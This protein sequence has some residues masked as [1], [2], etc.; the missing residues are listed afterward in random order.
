MNIPRASIFFLISSLVSSRGS[1]AFVTRF[2]YRSRSCSLFGGNCPVSE[3][4]FGLLKVEVDQFY[5]LFDKYKGSRNLSGDSEPVS[6]EINN[7]LKN[8]IDS[9]IDNLL[10]MITMQ[11]CGMANVKHALNEHEM[12]E[13]AMFL[14]GFQKK[15]TSS[16]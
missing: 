15:N 16:S 1:E 3:S 4:H 10:G 12:K 7:E 13:D 8:R 9:D 2:H 5:E 6:I 14:T 11:R